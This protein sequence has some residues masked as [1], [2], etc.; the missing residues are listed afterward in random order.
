MWSHCALSCG[1]VGVDVPPPHAVT[2]TSTI[3]A[4]IARHC[5]TGG[6]VCRSAR[7]DH[8]A[9]RQGS[10]MRSIHAVF[11][12]GLLA[13]AALADT[14]PNVEPKADQLLKRMSTEL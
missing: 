13:S 4:R 14:P 3:Q 12:A 10:V 11:A 9:R 6:R 1:S 7:C 2:N 8:S 5:T